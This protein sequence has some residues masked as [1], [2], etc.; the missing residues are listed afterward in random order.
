MTNLAFVEI[1][2][3]LLAGWSSELDCRSGSAQ[4]F[5]LNN[6]CDVQ[7]AQSALKFFRVRRSFRLQQSLDKVNEISV[8]EWFFQQ[9]NCSKAGGALTSRSQMDRS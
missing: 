1:N 6:V 7:I 9:M 3:P 8:R 4:A 2:T 5:K